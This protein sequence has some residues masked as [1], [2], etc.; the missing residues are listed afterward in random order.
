MR[1]KEFQKILKS[2]KIDAAIIMNYRS[3]DPNLLYF[4]QFETDFGILVAAKNLVKFVAA[5]MELERAKKSSIIKSIIKIEKKDRKERLFDFIKGLL[6]R[7]NVRR[8]GINKNIVSLNE[9]KEIKKSFKNIKFADIS[10][11]LNELRQKKTEK[12]VAIIKKACRISDGILKKCIK[13]FRKFKTEKDAAEFLEKEAKKNNCSLAFPT[14]VASGENSSMPHHKTSNAKLKKGFCI[15]DFGVKY[16][17]YCTDTTR[18]VYI[19]KPN[20]KEIEIY[21]LLLNLQKETIKEL[22]QNKNYK[23]IEE[24]VRKKLKKYNKNFIH[25]LGHSFGINIHEYFDNK[26]KE[27]FTITVEPGIYFEGKFGI[28]IEDSVLI[29]KKNAELLTKIPKDLIIVEM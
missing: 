26:L 5:A 29:K 10:K 24:T 19:G 23:I 1:L 2:K 20:E 18:T 4:T 6:K 7:Q 12:E 17:N 14:I 9:Y 16:K 13:D 3:K 15:I 25:G 8:M 27:N 21:T 11:I 28:R 22:R